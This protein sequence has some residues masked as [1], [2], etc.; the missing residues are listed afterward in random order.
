MLKQNLVTKRARRS[1]KQ[2][3]MI[4]IAI[5][6]LMALS[7]CASASQATTTPRPTQQLVELTPTPTY[8]LVI[9]TRTPQPTEDNQIQASSTPFDP[10]LNDSERLIVAQAVEDLT[11]RA[12]TTLNNIEFLQISEINW[13]DP[14]SCESDET[15]SLNEGVAGYHLWLLVDNLV[16][17][18]QSDQQS[19]QFCEEINALDTIPEI[20]VLVDP[21]ASEL[22][23]LA[24]RR[25]A[26]T[27]NISIRRIEIITLETAQWE[28]T[29]LGCPVGG[30]TYTPV[31]ANGYRIVL[32]AGGDLY[33]FHT[34]FSHIVLCTTESTETN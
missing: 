8:T 29:S 10:S 24:Q 23:T 18:Y 20:L 28:D 5:M 32:L 34:S 2:L 17:R 12:N 30:Q 25:V 19:A 16:Y 31:T 1:S 15:S 22:L 6:M 13:I 4:G 26:D 14:F 33:T 27:L 7:A 21:I 3:S 9:P 11:I